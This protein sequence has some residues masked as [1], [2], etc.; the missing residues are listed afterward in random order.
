MVIHFE[1]NISNNSVMV[2][3]IQIK[4]IKLCLLIFDGIILVDLIEI[5][6][7]NIQLSNN[8][9]VQHGLVNVPNQHDQ[10][11]VF[12][13]LQL[14]YRGVHGWN[15]VHFPAQLLDSSVIADVMLF[16]FGRISAVR[17]SNFIRA[18]EVTNVIGIKTNLE[19]LLS[20]IAFISFFLFMERH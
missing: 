15:L 1:G 11:F 7:W 12:E 17:K 16:V 14:I 6:Q 13:K 3:N 18:S 8:L 10:P 2:N 5:H 4:N 9:L 19:M 20:R